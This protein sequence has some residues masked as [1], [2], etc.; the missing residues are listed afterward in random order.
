MKFEKIGVHSLYGMSR[1]IGTMHK[2]TALL[3]FQI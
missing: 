1:W 3:L 2:D